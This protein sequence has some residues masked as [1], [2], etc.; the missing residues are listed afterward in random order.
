MITKN[1]LQPSYQHVLVFTLSQ[2]KYFHAPYLD[3][4]L[5]ITPYM[6]DRSV[7]IFHMNYINAVKVGPTA[8]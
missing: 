7:G 8:D 4:I 3:V 2:L 1:Y 5:I 6:S